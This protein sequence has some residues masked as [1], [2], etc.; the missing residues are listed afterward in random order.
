MTALFEI[1]AGSAAITRRIL[2]VAPLVGFMGAKDRYAADILRHWPVADPGAFVLNDL[3]YWGDIWPA[4][5]N[6]ALREETATALDRL[7]GYPPREAWDLAR[8]SAADLSV[9][10][11]AAARLCRIAGTYGG[12]EVGGFKGRHVRRPNV[13]GF[14][15]SRRTLAARV[16]GMPRSAMVRVSATRL[17][18][19]AVAAPPGSY[20]FID[21]PY[22]GRSKYTNDFP[23]SS[24]LAVAARARDAGCFVAVCEGVPLAGE[25]GAGW[26]SVPVASSGGQGRRNSVG[27]EEY[28][29]FSV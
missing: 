24:V 3:G 8:S 12:G 22:A 14:I 13:D 26:V 9:P 11:L 28:L 10:D 4:L 18:A 5:V 6:D 23:R 17:D 2:G 7:A 19:A 25:L 16:R 15:P 21:P 29:T 1:C 20:V 27:V